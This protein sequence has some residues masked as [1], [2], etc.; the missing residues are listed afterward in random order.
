MVETAFAARHN[1]EIP[2]VREKTIYY[3]FG[4][5]RSGKS[6][7]L[8]VYQKKN[9]TVQVCK[10]DSGANMFDEYQFEDVV[11]L[12]EVKGSHVYPQDITLNIML[13]MLDKHKCTLP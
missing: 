10:L 6:E 1:I 3:H 7:T 12:D 4:E 11:F 2:P 8:L 13:R 5:S 9:P